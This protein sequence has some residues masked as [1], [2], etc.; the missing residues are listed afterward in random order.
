MN[1]GVPVGNQAVLLKGV[2]DTPEK[3]LELCKKLLKIRVRPYYV[4]HPHSVEGTEHL[5][6][7]VKKGAL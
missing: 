4:F 7:S 3:M 6:V 5:R 1:N 2:N